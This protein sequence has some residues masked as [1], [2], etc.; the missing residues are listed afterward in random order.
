MIGSLGMSFRIVG[1]ILAAQALSSIGTSMSTVALAV[2]V[3]KLTG[4][5]LQMGGIMARVHCPAGA[6][7]LGGRRLPRPLQRP[8]HHGGI[9]LVRA[10]LIFSMPFLAGRNVGFVYWWPRSWASSRA[11]STRGRSSSS[12]RSSPSEHLVR[13]NSYLGVSRD[14]AELVGYLVGGRD[15]VHQQPHHPGRDRSPATPW[16][17]PS[18]PS[19]TWCRPCCW[20]GCRAALVR[21]GAG[22]GLRRPHAGV[23][24]GAGPAL[25]GAGA[26]HQPAAGRVRRRARS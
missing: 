17:S 3:Y 14:G 9:R 13:A 16:P 20:W 6:H 7:G 26:A 18:T 24:R 22:P 12:G 25:A 5:V 23:A 21:E 11:C 19:A 2:M 15:R 10:V 1:R 4:S 8:Q